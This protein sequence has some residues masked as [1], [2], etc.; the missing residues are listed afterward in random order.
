MPLIKIIEEFRQRIIIRVKTNGR[1][2]GNLT[3]F[4]L[5]SSR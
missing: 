4:V 1:G 3:I 2:G 5:K